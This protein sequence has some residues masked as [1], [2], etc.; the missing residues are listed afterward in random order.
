[1]KLSLRDEILAVLDCEVPI[2]G[3]ELMRGV[4][5]LRLGNANIMPVESEGFNEAL[6]HAVLNEKL[7]L[8]WMRVGIQGRNIV[9]S[10]VQRHIFRS[11]SSSMLYYSLSRRGEEEQSHLL[12]RVAEERNGFRSVCCVFMND[13]L[14]RI[15][16]Q[17]H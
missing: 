7:A 15:L 13:A 3:R 4:E 6:Q 5:R 8:P 12:D 10:S 14:S 17:N 9:F 2:Q 1:M 11:T 16:D